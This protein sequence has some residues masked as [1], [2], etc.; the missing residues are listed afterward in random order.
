MVSAQS[1]GAVYG[2]ENNKTLKYF[3]IHNRI[4]GQNAAKSEKTVENG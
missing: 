3:E 1:T 2:A 4:G